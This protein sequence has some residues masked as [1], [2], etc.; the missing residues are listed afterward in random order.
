MLILRMLEHESLL[1]I[2]VRI[3]IVSR[4]CLTDSVM[5]VWSRLADDEKKRCKAKLQPGSHY[6][7]YF[8]KCQLEMHVNV[9]FI[10]SMKMFNEALKRM[11]M[12]VGAAEYFW[13]LNEKVF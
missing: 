13:S 10:T 3:D 12:H 2:F 4:F 6:D 7:C 5:D 11:H 9:D 1:D 8:W